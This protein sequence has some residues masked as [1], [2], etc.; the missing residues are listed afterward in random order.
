MYFSF[1]WGVNVSRETIK[2]MKK[3]ERCP[4]CE[5]KSLQEIFQCTDHTVSRETFGIS[6]CKSCKLLVTN[7]QP[8]A[9]SL[10]AYYKSEEYISHTNSTKGTFNKLYQ[11]VRKRTLKGKLK[12]LGK[13][14]GLLLEIGCG[15]GELLAECQKSGWTVKGVEPNADA[16]SLAI[17]N[18]RLDI[19]PSIKEL[20]I[21]PKSLDRIML[22]HVLEHIPNLNETLEE[23][24]DWLKEDGK[25]FIAVPNPSSWDAKH[26]KE[27]WAAYDV[28][29]HLSHFTR[30]SMK[31]LVNKHGLQIKQIKPMWF[32]A[33]YVAM[34]SEKIK[35][36][37]ASL[38]KGAFIGLLSNIFAASARKEFSS[39][40]YIIEHKN[41]K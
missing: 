29:R 28:P 16:R 19:L 27:A 4:S 34:L 32:D 38:L 15:T 23:L 9:N 22:W 26:Y 10:G 2:R 14:K 13:N 12:M 11:L 24:A 36:G 1:I 21:T 3:I 6:E 30:H 35:G 5:S 7:P 25:L 37:R 41:A 39:L 31:T 18:H 8:E 40:I 17:K 20:N 33:F